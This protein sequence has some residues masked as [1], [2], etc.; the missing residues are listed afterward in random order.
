DVCVWGAKRA[1]TGPRGDGDFDRHGG[2]AVHW[3][4]L[5]KDGEGV[6]ERVVGVYVCGAGDSS[7][8]RVRDRVEHGD[9]LHAEPVDLHD[10]V[11]AAG[12]C[13]CAERTGVG[14]EDIFCDGVYAAEYSRGKDIGAYQ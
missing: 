12:T 8:P 13:F 2:D 6:S 3:D 7:E 14:L 10:L 11:R 4:Q 9:G 1:W 5:R